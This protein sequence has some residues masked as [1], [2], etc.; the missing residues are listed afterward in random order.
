MGPAHFQRPLFCILAALC[1]WS[2]A[3]SDANLPSYPLAVKSPYL[4][5]WMPGSQ[6]KNAATGQPQFWTGQPLTW[7]I[8]AK[9]GHTSYTLFGAPGG[10]SGS[11]AATTK[12]VSY[13]SSHT[14]VTLFAGPAAFV[15]DFFSPVFPGSASYAKQSLPYSYLTVNVTSSSSQSIQILSAID[16]TWTAQGGASALNWTTSGSAGFFWFFNANAGAYTEKN[17]MGTYGSVLFGTTVS[18]SG[19]THACDTPAN[20][21]KAFTSTGTLTAKSSCG[22]SD[23]AAVS[24]DLG[25]TTSGRV[26][27]AI[28]FDRVRAVQYLGADQ[29]GYYRKQWPNV[30]SAISYFLGNYDSALSSSL[31]FDAAVRS[32]ASSVSSAY[33]SQYADILEA[34]VRQTFGG[35]EITVP[36]D[37]IAAS[38]YVFM[39][40]ISSDGNVNTVDFIYQTWPIFVSLNP[41]YIKL[42][43]AP[44]LDY[45]KGGGWPHPWVIHDIGSAYP[46]ATGHNDGNAEQMPL[47]ETSSLFILLLAYQQCTGDSS[48]AKQYS[49]QF[50]GWAD[51][52]AKNSLYPA[53]QLISADA[54]PAS[55]NQTALA[56]QAAIG[57][58]AAGKLTGNT[59]YSDTAS[60]MA[61]K[62]YND[63]LGLD[64]PTLAKSTHFTYNYGKSATWNAV[65]AGYSD[66][67]LNLTTFPSTAWSMQS[68]WYAKQM[69]DGGLP[70]AGPP[71]DR[72]VNW[73]L[74]DWNFVAAAVSSTDVQQ[75]VVSSTWKFMTNGKNSIPFGT[76][77]YVQ[78][79]NEGLWIGNKARSSVGSHFAILALQQGTWGNGY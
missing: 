12:S 75:Q 22:G 77:H 68:S 53:S 25:T 58:N 28:G 36:A 55:A 9:V 24:K 51:Y 43:L 66:V 32:K 48:F 34:S 47:F 39:K 74:T 46:K 26:T 3:T 18:G 41:E 64:G 7:S 50:P 61:A 63:A 33:G 76:K 13:S 79:S 56:M 11:T 67:V 2:L 31:S 72:G 19:V 73:A 60:S 15:L 57:L 21:Y 42:L 70:F 5:A 38:P 62:I 27:F 16:H 17:D 6:I 20:V 69:Q 40:E 1:S 30:E 14:Y 49:A 45:M 65:F 37:N 54:I 59:G 52:L 78:G 35:I 23:L 29:T 44:V 71:S 8:V 4:S 10:I